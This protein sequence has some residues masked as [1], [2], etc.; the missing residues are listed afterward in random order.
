MGTEL[1][2]QYNAE[3]NPLLKLGFN[4]EWNVYKATHKQRNIP[5]SIFVLEKKKLK[6]LG[7]NQKNIIEQLKKITIELSKF[8]HPNILSV[9]QKNIKLS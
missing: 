5:V 2:K 6:N 7:G 3:K 4:L 1:F 8:K 9:I